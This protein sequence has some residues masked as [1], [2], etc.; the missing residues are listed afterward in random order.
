[1][2]EL[3]VECEKGPPS[4]IYTIPRAG[5]ETAETQQ[6][7]SPGSST[8]HPHGV[9]RG[10]ET[11]RRAGP[12]LCC[13]PQ[14][15]SDGGSGWPRPAP[16][17]SPA[18]AHCIFAPAGR[19]GLGSSGSLSRLAPPGQS[20]APRAGRA[21]GGL[22]GLSLPHFFPPGLSNSAPG[23]P[24]VRYPPLQRSPSGAGSAGQLVS[25]TSLPSGKISGKYRPARTI[26]CAGTGEEQKRGSVSVSDARRVPGLL[27]GPGC[28]H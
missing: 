1:M 7:V 2:Q 16:R 17:S 14:V 6:R 15:R 24:S 26:H 5:P 19:G 23:L 22:Q 10:R 18:V 9:A 4:H 25:L 21:H 3:L 27:K 11:L 12:R 20:G 13:L 8:P 28:S